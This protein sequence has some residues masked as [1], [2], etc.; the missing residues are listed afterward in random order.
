[1][2]ELVVKIAHFQDQKNW[3]GVRRGRNHFRRLDLSIHYRTPFAHGVPMNTGLSMYPRA[4][5]VSVLISHWDCRV[6]MAVKQFGP[7]GRA[8]AERCSA[9][10]R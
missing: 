6:G 4:G 5:A 10:V 3:R 7:P 8:V 2:P 1:M 9:D